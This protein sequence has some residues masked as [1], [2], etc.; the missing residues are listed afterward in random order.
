MK[1]ERMK[2]VGGDVDF[3]SL[4][5]RSTNPSTNELGVA[6]GSLGVATEDLNWS[7]IPS[8]SLLGAGPGPSKIAFGDSDVGY[9][10]HIPQSDLISYSD[11]SSQLG[12]PGAFVEDHTVGMWFKYAHNGRTLFV[13]QRGIKTGVSWEQL[14]LLGLVY[15]DDTYG[16]FPSGTQRRQSGR[17]TIGNITYKVRLLTG[18][19]DDPSNAQDETDTRHSSLSDSEWTKLIV[20]TTD[21]TWASFSDRDMGFINSGQT[22]CQESKGPDRLLHGVNS[23]YDTYFRSADDAS[24]YRGW[25]PVLEVE[26]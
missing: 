6:G 15:G 23:A 12:V 22:W 14:Y 19:S 9:F 20:P 10:G 5:E 21:G 13:A 1:L 2:L 4:P 25:R 8:A 16:R 7:N 18:S 24:S 11:L 17:V 26:E 3:L